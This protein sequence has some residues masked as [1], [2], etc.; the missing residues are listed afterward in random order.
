MKRLVL[1]KLLLIITVVAFSCRTKYDAF[2]VETSNLANTSELIAPDSSF[3]NVIKSY[4]DSLEKDMSTV[5][6]ISE[7]EMDKDKPEGLLS[8]FMGD[9]LLEE[10]KR[11]CKQNNLSFLPDMAYV[12]YGGIRASLPKGK[13]TVRNVFELMP[14]ENKM[15]FVKLNGLKMKEFLDQLASNGGDG[16]AGIKFG[17]KESKATNIIIGLEKLSDVKEYWIVTNDYVAGGGDKMDVL[18]NDRID[19]LDSEQLLREIIINN[20]S[21]KYRNG[22]IIQSK[23]DGRIYNE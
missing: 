20:L 4:K 10:G 21:E 23:L 13:I 12:N 15:V 5:I 19:F 9:L 6:G 8:N 2:K 3:A 14:F 11:Y 16:V 18:K 22:E 7:I 1:Y 17:I